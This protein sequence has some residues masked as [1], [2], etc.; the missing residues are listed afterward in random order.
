[1]IIFTEHFRAWL[2]DDRIAH[3]NNENWLIYETKLI[4]QNAWASFIVHKWRS[5]KFEYERVLIS[6]SE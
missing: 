6:R 3:D 5:G 2:F 1:M 4:A